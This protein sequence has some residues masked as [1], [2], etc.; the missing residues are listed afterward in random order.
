MYL[1]GGIPGTDG[2]AA[3]VLFRE[4]QVGQGR[5]EMRKFINR[6]KSGTVGALA[7]IASSVVVIGCG[8]S[9][10]GTSSPVPKDTLAVKGLYM[11]MPGDDAV[12]ACKEMI[13]SSE[14]LV[15]VD[16]R[17]GI[18][19]E[20]DEET[21]A[22]EKKDWET[23]VKLAETDIDLFQKWNS[24]NGEVYDPSV[25]N[26][27]GRIPDPHGGELFHD[28]PFR[29]RLKWMSGDK[30]AR[31]PGPQWTL[32]SAMAVF[33]GIYGYQVEWMLPGKRKSDKEEKAVP[34]LYSGKVSVP[35]KM[36][37]SSL[38]S[39]WD[40]EVLKK[41][42][43]GELYS[44]GLQLSKENEKR[45]FF[46]LAFED[47]Q[48]NPVDKKKLATEL[49]LDN[50]MFFEEFGSN[51]EKIEAA[52]KELEGFL[53]WVEFLREQNFGDYSI[54]GVRLLDP[55]DPRPENVK[56][57]EKR[58]AE[59]MADM[60]KRGDSR[61]LEK[62]NMMRKRQGLP[63]L[64][65]KADRKSPVDSTQNKAA[66][67]QSSVVSAEIK[68]LKAQLWQMEKTKS[69]L[70]GE[71][72]EL[73]KRWKF[74]LNTVKNRNEQAKKQP[75][76]KNNPVF[77]E[78]NAKDKARLA[79]MREKYDAAREK[80]NNVASSIADMK[81][82]I[83]SKEAEVRKE[84]AAQEKAIAEAKAAEEKVAA[85][86]KATEETA[87]AKKNRTDLRFLTAART[88]SYNRTTSNY[89]YQFS[90]T[91]KKMAVNCNV[92]LE[93]AVLTEPAD[94]LE[95]ITEVFSIP[96]GD[97]ESA[98][99]FVNKMNV[100]LGKFSEST[101]GS[102]GSRKRIYFEK[103]L[104]DIYSPL[105]FRLVLKTTNGVEVAKADAV[106]NW[107][108]ARGHRPPSDKMIIPKKNL[109]QISIKKDGVREDKLAGLCFVW[110]DDQGDVR[111]AY[112]NEKGIDRFFNAEDLSC[113][114]FA[115]ALVKNYSKI[116]I[117]E[118]QVKRDDLEKGSIQE[119]SWIYKDPKGYQVKLFERVFLDVDGRK[120][121]S[122]MIE[123]LS[124][125]NP[126]FALGIAVLALADK[127]PEKFLVFSAIK[128]Q[129][130]RKFD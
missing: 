83:A 80:R 67:T 25:E 81:A 95:E 19:R 89:A 93:W 124:K 125:N 96:A 79:D 9:S 18:E 112:F 23:R 8:D 41:G 34:K 42:L 33:A 2:N 129:S 1:E 84:I 66:S 27:E 94:K 101:V 71:I 3:L 24:L 70:D 46:R 118:P 55:D 82:K 20:K 26:C 47:A 122:K 37:D 109:I 115:H 58:D 54:K 4:T 11:G 30:S 15:V 51:Q 59:V 72:A 126:E 87:L 117:L 90:E 104:V 28:E 16:F 98:V 43:L 45:V 110:I 88:G 65:V 40:S 22:K 61:G 120:Y 50:P 38:Y 102:D 121:D 74:L 108:E 100:N 29:P 7:L 119:T 32:A 128:P 21:K 36:K 57:A 64:A 13:G 130:E 105:W 111:Q 14:D 76:L 127:R 91:M 86:K 97:Y 5:D 78:S 63:P 116:P 52:E 56:E 53:L 31:V 17:N 114:E 77:K 103:D 49:V 106:K 60:A 123:K 75:S 39:V 107:L 48:G 113:E 73:G 68:K 12:K 44:K 99:K 69:S 92:M 6:W 85:E 35:E 10:D 62:M